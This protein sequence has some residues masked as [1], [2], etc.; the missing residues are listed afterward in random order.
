MTGKPKNKG[1]LEKKT[2]TREPKASGNMELTEEEIDALWAT[3]PKE[4]EGGS[5]T[6]IPVPRRRR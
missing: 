6:L 1:K 5:I 2:K 3:R 4:Y